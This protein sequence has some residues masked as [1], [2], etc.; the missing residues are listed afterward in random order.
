MSA[1]KVQINRSARFI[2]QQ[3]VQLHGGIGMTMEYKGGHY[4]KRLTTI[5]SLFGDTDYHLARLAS[6]DGLLDG[7]EA[8]V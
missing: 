2:G 4:F 5:E 8:M 7:V 3:A 1:V 6:E